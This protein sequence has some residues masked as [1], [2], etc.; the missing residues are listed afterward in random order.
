M[1][2]RPKNGAFV[3]GIHDLLI[4][5]VV[6]LFILARDGFLLFFAGLEVLLVLLV[7]VLV[8]SEIL[9]VRRDRVFLMLPVRFHEIL[10]CVPFPGTGNVPRWSAG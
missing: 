10:R 5:I 8:V 4:A 2:E 6:V 1:H 3:G 9:L 7:Y